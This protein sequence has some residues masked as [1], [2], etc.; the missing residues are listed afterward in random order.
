M[1]GIGRV[2]Q[3]GKRWWIAFYAP[4]TKIGKRVEMRESAGD[5]EQEAQK[6][7]EA[8]RRELANDEDGIAAFAGPEIEKVRVAKI[9]DDYIAAQR[10]KRARSLPQMKSRV[11]RLKGFFRMRAL[12]LRSD[13]IRQYIEMRQK[14]DAKEATINKEVGVL[15]AAF[16][17]AKKEGRI[18]KVPAFPDKLPENN[19]RQGFFELS[20]YLAIR[21][22]INDVDVEEY[23]D[24]FF[25][26][27]MRNDEIKSLTWDAYDRETE[28]IRLHA[29]HAKT[30][31]GRVLAVE[32]SLQDIIS[33]RLTARRL[34]C[35]FIFHR[36]GKRM[37]EFRKTWKT[38]CKKAGIVA[39]REGRTPYDL[40]RTGI[41]NMVRAGVNETVA[42]A[43]SGHRTR[44]VFDRYNITNEDDI[45]EAVRNTDRYVST[46]PTERKTA[47]IKKHKA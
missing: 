16:N 31:H 21:S 29:S 45:R 5:T 17:L 9:L 15:S 10:I 20:D 23:M 41:R 37:G 40:R 30:G 43:I 47:V 38:A 44:D 24:F 13:R 26:T 39:G 25:A 6:Q 14:D 36:G 28:T 11:K 22:H 33:R 19:A 3:R 35:V 4:D 27:A 12:A 18:L 8:R 7:L 46:L 34:G 32:G 42:R 1:K 2:F